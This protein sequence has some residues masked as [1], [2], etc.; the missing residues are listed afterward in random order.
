M[1]K[2]IQDGLRDHFSIGKRGWIIKAAAAAGLCL[3]SVFLLYVF[4]ELYDRPS[5]EEYRI[6]G[7]LAGSTPLIQEGDTLTYDFVC[8][9][10]T[11]RNLELFLDR[12]G[13]APMALYVVRL[14][15]TAS[16]ELI[17]QVSD[18][19]TTTCGDSVNV[20]PTQTVGLRG[21]SIR[22]ELTLGRTTEQTY[23]GFYLEEPEENGE[24]A[25][26]NGIPLD[27]AL[28]LNLNRAPTGQTD[29]YKI[30]LIL[31]GAAVLG[32]LT[33]LGRDHAINAVVLIITF[34][35]FISVLNPIGDS[36][37]EEAH[38]IRA[39]TVRQGMLFTTAD[40]PVEVDGGVYTLMELRDLTTYNFVKFSD[41]SYYTIRS[42]IDH[43][44]TIAGTAASYIFLGYLVPAAGLAI[45]NMFHLPA[46]I[47]I[48]LCRAL[49][50]LQ[51]AALCFAAIKLTLRYK[52]TFA[53]LCCFPLCVYLAASFNTDGLTYGLCFLS[54]AYLLRLIDCGAHHTG[55]K[56]TALYCAIAL[57]LSLTKISYIAFLP[58]LFA[59]PKENFKSKKSRIAAWAFL[60]LAAAIATVWLVLSGAHGLRVID[61]TDSRQQLYFLM[62]HPGRA[63]NIFFSSF[64][65]NWTT[66]YQQGFTLGWLYYNFSYVGMIFPFVVWFCLL[67]E[68]Q[69]SILTRWSQRAWVF[70]CLFGVLTLTYLAMYISSNPVGST[71]V[72]GIQGRY[73][74]GLIAL[75]PPLLALPGERMEGSRDRSTLAYPLWSAA[76]LVICVST[77]TLRHY[78]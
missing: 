77:I 74:V 41:A 35:F 28:A 13:G 46:M 54:V 30:L 72:V 39:D 47:T 11:L 44:T 67:G 40:T 2:V 12:K 4:G 75:V 6:H 21:K 69:G 29:T 73:F 60:F 25:H 76:F 26:L 53:L 71:S 18:F 9:Y 5:A 58:L 37:D 24:V 8:P 51:Y 20:L 63:L 45:G 56:Q 66:L 7:E 50:V 61:G 14:F 16:G 19:N 64:F 1:I 59:I 22:L 43:A 68:Q 33:L 17:A 3:L 31:L 10:D 32:A 23:C 57:V 42:G 52:R 38:F 62:T 15:D 48:Y 34:G 70:L 27:G 36:P 65:N 49:N 78:M 55:I